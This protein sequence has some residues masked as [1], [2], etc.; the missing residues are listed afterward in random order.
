MKRQFVVTRTVRQIEIPA[1]LQTPSN[2]SCVHKKFA[3]LVCFIVG[4]VRIGQDVSVCNKMVLA[5]YEKLLFH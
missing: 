3:I 4:L 2:E 1:L 5:D